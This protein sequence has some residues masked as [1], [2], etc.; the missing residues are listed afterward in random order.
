[1]QRIPIEVIDDS[2]R[3]R[4][5]AVCEGVAAIGSSQASNTYRTLINRNKEWH[6]YKHSTALQ[7][8][9]KGEQEGKEIDLEV[10][11]DN[12]TI[13]IARTQSEYQLSLPYIAPIDAYG[14]EIECFSRYAHSSIARHMSSYGVPT[15]TYPYIKKDTWVV[16]EDQTI[17]PDAGYYEGAEIQSPVLKPEIVDLDIDMVCDA[18]WEI[19]ADVN[20]TCGLHVH[21]SDRYLSTTD[22]AK[23]AWQAIRNERTIDSLHMP[24]RRDSR[25]EFTAGWS[26]KNGL[27]RGGSIADMRKDLKSVSEYEQL[28][29]VVNPAGRRYKVNFR[30]LESDL[31]TVEFRQHHGTIE[32]EDIIQWKNFVSC[33]TQYSIN[34]GFEDKTDPD[35]L[36]ELLANL[37]DYLPEDD[38]MPFIRFFLK[39]QDQVRVDNGETLGDSINEEPPD[40]DLEAQISFDHL[41]RIPKEDLPF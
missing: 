31:P 15:T 30:T 7:D 33:F 2:P 41:I 14:I 3:N 8:W 12:C 6:N 5:I 32:A 27:L 10:D 21:I 38:K 11:H 1:M 36:L 26:D 20:V 18:L 25:N 39:R 40:Y 34:T 23:L 22:K 24:V 29:S 4:V 19:H 9:L 35:D 16:K 28:I 37:S 13:G 17:G